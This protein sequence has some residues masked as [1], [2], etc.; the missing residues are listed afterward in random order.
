MIT[1]TRLV[2]V[3]IR[4]VRSPLLWSVLAI[5]VGLRVTSQ[6]GFTPDSVFYVDIGSAFARAGT[7]ATY[8]LNATSMQIP[9]KAILWP[10]LYPA[11]LGVF[12]HLG[13]GTVG[14]IRAVSVV[15]ILGLTLASFALARRMAGSG[16]AALAAALVLWHVVDTPA[17]RM[18]WSEPL[19]VACGMGFLHFLARHL[20]SGRPAD[21]ALAAMLAAMGMLTRYAGIFMV[22]VGVIAIL[23]RRDARDVMHRAPWRRAVLAVLMA[24]ALAPLLLWS[25]RNL[26]LTGHAFGPPRPH[27]ATSPGA[28]VLAACRVLWVESPLL[29]LALGALLAR[30]VYLD[31]R[32]R[33][34]SAS[35]W[36]IPALILIYVAA[37]IGLQIV[38]SSRFAMDRVNSRL[39]CPC[40][41]PLLVLAAVLACWADPSKPLDAARARFGVRTA[42]PCVISAALIIGLMIRTVPADRAAWQAWLVGVHV[43]PV[44]PQLEWIA[45]HQASR[46]LF[47]GQEA[48]DVRLYKGRLVLLDGYPEFPRLTRANITT[49]LRRF[50]TEFDQVYLIRARPELLAEFEGFPIVATPGPIVD[51]SALLKGD[52]NAGPGEYRR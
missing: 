4:I 12:T 3:L 31:T 14:A 28:N 18:V 26:A 24:L 25:W 10:P 35:A 13:L 38:I 8:M 36:C 21:V 52:D 37:T 15:A 16:A 29:L 19:F 33:A 20:N 47:V 22:P 49:F 46:V 45:Q 5:C 17:Y 51:L 39:L 50:R 42:W 11:A 23:L 2:V 32:S 1:E 41:P 27:T 40:Y 44:N 9:D 43:P 34:R 30:A 7:F 6:P 48:W